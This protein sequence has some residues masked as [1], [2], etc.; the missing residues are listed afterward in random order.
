MRFSVYTLILSI[1]SSV[2]LLLAQTITCATSIG[3]NGVL[4]TD[5]NAKTG[6]LFFRW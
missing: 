2:Q 4:K 6:V 3:K 5:S 1:L